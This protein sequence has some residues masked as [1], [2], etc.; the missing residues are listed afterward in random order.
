MPV[1]TDLFG[2]CG[3]RFES[4]IYSDNTYSLSRVDYQGR[5]FLAEVSDAS[6]VYQHRWPSV[7]GLIPPVSSRDLPGQQKLVLFDIGTDIVLCEKIN[8]V[9]RFTSEEAIDLAGMALDIVSDLQAAGMICGYIG[10]EMLVLHGSSILMLAGRRGIPESPFTA[11]E[12]QSSRPSDPRSDVSAIGSLLFRLVAGTDNREQ[13]L[14]IWQELSAEMQTAIQDMVA[15]SPVNRPNGLKAVK[16][17]LDGLAS[18]G[19]EEADEGSF[20]QGQAFTRPE[21]STS[22]TGNHRKLY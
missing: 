18:N 21:G 6:G 7:A 4:E 22:S 1:D 19:N 10:P 12:I 16:S 15:A 11:P 20:D 17:I 3:L 13:Q 8:T 14:Q 9:G 2:S 5:K